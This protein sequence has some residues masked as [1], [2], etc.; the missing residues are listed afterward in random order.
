MSLW[1][2]KFPNE[3]S[4]ELLNISKVYNVAVAK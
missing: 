1:E 3:S 2:L 4:G